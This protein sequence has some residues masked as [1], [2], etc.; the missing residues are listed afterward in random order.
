MA[1]NPADVRLLTTELPLQGERI[2]SSWM[3]WV[4][5]EKSVSRAL[6][7]L[8][9]YAASHDADAVI[10]VRIVANLQFEVHLIQ[11]DKYGPRYTAYGT[12][13]IYS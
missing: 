12:A 10:G 6:E 11:D 2:S 7:A 13:V 5:E 1:K 8:R 9:T 3:V 4:S